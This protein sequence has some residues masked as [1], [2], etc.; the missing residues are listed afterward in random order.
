MQSVWSSVRRAV[1]R[2]ADL[3]ITVPLPDGTATIKTVQ[4][5]P[6]WGADTLIQV[7]VHKQGVEWVQTFDRVE[8]AKE[9]LE[10]DRESGF[11]HIQHNA[12]CL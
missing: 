5:G 2:G 7:L 12:V 11:P 9:A 8:G 4:G 1:S 3:T 6:L 10:R